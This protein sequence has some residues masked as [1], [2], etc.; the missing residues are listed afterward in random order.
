[1]TGLGGADVFL[2]GDSR[3]IFYNDGNKKAEGRDDYARITDFVRGIDKLQVVDARYAFQSTS[4][5]TELYLQQGRSLE[6]I[7]VLDG[8]NTLTS[9]D[10]IVV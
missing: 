8:V 7:A 5:G 6:L 9:S 4:S 2:L 1:M 10:F 3:G